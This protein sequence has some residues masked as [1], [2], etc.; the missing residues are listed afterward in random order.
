M[1]LKKS[2][3]RWTTC[4]PKHIG[5]LQSILLLQFSREGARRT[6]AASQNKRLMGFGEGE[7]KTRADKPKRQIK[8]AFWHCF[9]TF[10]DFIFK[11]ET[12]SY[13]PA[14]KQALVNKGAI[15]TRCPSH[16]FPANQFIL[17]A[18]LSLVSY[19]FLI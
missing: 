12:D 10:A 6:Q 11:I 4:L 15:D 13:F 9:Q 3:T 18:P 19:I 7:E 14:P 16:S 17:V 1:A 8:Q 5:T 2:L